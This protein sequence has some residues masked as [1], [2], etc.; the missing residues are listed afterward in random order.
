MTLNKNYSYLDTI[1]LRLMNLKVLDP[2]WYIDEFNLSG[3]RYSGKTTNVTIEVAKIFAVAIKHQKTVGLYAFRYLTRQKQDLIDEIKIALDDIDLEYSFTKTNGFK[4][5]NGSFIK[6]Y[7]VHSPSG[8][9]NMKGL[10]KCDNFDLAIRWVEEANELS[11]ADFQAIDFAIRGAKRFTKISTCNPDMVYQDHIKY[12]NEIVPFNEKAMKEKNQQLEIV[13]RLGSRIL[14]HY[15]NFKINPHLSIDIV[16]NLEQLKILDPVRAIPWYYGLP[17]ALGGS[18][19]GTYLALKNSVRDFTPNEFIAGVDIGYSES[20]TS[21][22]TVAIFGS[23]NKAR[24]HVHIES[25]YFHDNSEMVVKTKEQ[26]IKEVVTYF[27]QEIGKTQ[28][29]SKLTIY[30][31]YGSGGY[32]WIDWANKAVQEYG[33]SQIMEFVPV[34][35]EVWY[36]KDRVEGIQIMLSTKRL[37]WS[38]NVCPNLT[39]TMG[40]MKYK[41]VKNKETYK[42]DIVDLND[43]LFDAMCYSMMPIIRE[44]MHNSKDIFTKDRSFI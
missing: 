43:D 19:F 23:V 7:G 38:D 10:A 20:P 34:D 25:E 29:R 42:V 2:K 27:M 32:L 18:V 1:A 24:N 35:K 15:S 3:S 26:I 30:T 8:R 33:Y 22:P 28:L 44:V 6:I 37:S 17:G 39:R 36:I 40:L 4:F 5:S 9:I 14:N 13:N 41:E 12:L 21:H 31:D 16:T 11:K